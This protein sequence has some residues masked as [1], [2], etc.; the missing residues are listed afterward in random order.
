M[1]RDGTLSCW[2][3]GMFGELGDH[4]GA[5]YQLHVTPTTAAASSPSSWMKLGGDGSRSYALD[6]NGRFWLWG[7]TSILSFNRAGMNGSFGLYSAAPVQQNG[8]Y[9]MFSGGCLLGTDGS[10]DCLRYSPFPTAL[11]YPLVEVPLAIVKVDAGPW[12]SMATDGGTFCAIDATAAA[13]CWGTNTQGQLGDGTTTDSPTPKKLAVAGTWAQLAVGGG[14]VCGVQTDGSLW[15]WGSPL[16]GLDGHGPSAVSVVP[17]ARIGS[18]TDW[19][20]VAI[21]DSN[22]ACARKTTG[23]IACWGYNGVGNIGDGTTTTRTTPTIVGTDTDWTQVTTGSSHTCAL[24]SN[25][26]AWCWGGNGYG[27]VGD[28]TRVANR[29]SP[30]R[31]VDSGYVAI[32]AHASTTCGIKTDGSIACWGADDSAQAGAPTEWS[33]ALRAIALP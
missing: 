17:P 19:A 20:Q 12:T 24:K 27:Q 4:G 18:D 10:I 14:D 25:G 13:W 26:A 9:T 1:K 23:A 16:Y 22:F 3:D 15:C 33:S 28:G 32:D 6:G 2:G 7:V 5:A 11:T 8:T 21:G 31:V 29:P 30:T